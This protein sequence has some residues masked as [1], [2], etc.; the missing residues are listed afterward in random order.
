MAKEK[1]LR[2]PKITM[3]Q[4]NRALMMGTLEAA[5]NREYEKGRYQGSEKGGPALAELN[6]FRQGKRRSR[7]VKP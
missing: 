4:I 7:R 2:P 6:A 1:P 3:R 5:A